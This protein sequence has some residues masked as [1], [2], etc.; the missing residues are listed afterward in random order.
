MPEM[1]LSQADNSMLES[2]INELMMARDTAED[3]FEAEKH[4]NW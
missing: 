1:M 3:P 2:A 4:N